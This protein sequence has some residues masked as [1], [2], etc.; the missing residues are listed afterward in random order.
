MHSCVIRSCLQVKK[1]VTKNKKQTAHGGIDPVTYCTASG[2]STRR[3][4]SVLTYSQY[5]TTPYHNTF[6]A[7]SSADSLYI[8]EHEVHCPSWSQDTN[9][10][11][12]LCLS[13]VID[14]VQGSCLILRP[15][16]AESGYESVI[17][18]LVASS[19]AIVNNATIVR[20]QDVSG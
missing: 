3:A 10:H 7:H 19:I 6:N 15:E 11:T 4:D 18:L 14:Q 8:N 1:L 13:L 9:R 16:S 12:C 20:R 2:C 5:V 17:M